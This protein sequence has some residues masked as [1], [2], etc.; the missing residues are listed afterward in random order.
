MSSSLKTYLF[1][2]SILAFSIFFVAKPPEGGEK[3]ER[4]KEEV[5]TL[6]INQFALYS[7]RE[8]RPELLV[9][10]SKALKFDDREEMFDFF[11]ANFGIARS[12]NSSFKKEDVEYFKVGHAVKKKDKY[13]FYRGIDYLNEAGM[14]FV[15]KEGIYNSWIKVFDSIGD[16]ELKNQDGTFAGVNLHY[17]GIKQEMSALSPRGE[18]W[19]ENSL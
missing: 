11:L 9:I 6:E 4:S 10:G 1:F 13:F 5:A 3:K 18:I 19:L 16:F 7:I 15:A 17:D 12:K 8:S 2:L 14:S